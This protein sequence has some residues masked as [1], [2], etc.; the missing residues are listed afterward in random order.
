LPE[1]DGEL[2]SG[3]DG[4][5]SQMS[6]GTFPVT[7]GETTPMRSKS[8]PLPILQPMIAPMGA[9]EIILR[10]LLVSIPIGMLAGAL[11][12][13]AVAFWFWR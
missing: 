9:N 2:P 8:R 12:A 10:T 7:G 11:I 13:A 3:G 5:G 1:D 6:Q 4:S